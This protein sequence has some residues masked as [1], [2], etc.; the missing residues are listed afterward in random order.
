[1]PNCFK[2]MFL[3]PP[4]DR[5]GLT[6][7]SNLAF[8][9][10]PLLPPPE[11][12]DGPN[13]NAIRLLSRFSLRDMLI[14][15][16]P[17]MVIGGALDRFSNLAFAME[18]DECC[19]CCNSAGLARFLPDAREIL[20]HERPDL[21]A[22]AAVNFLAD[23]ELILRKL[24]DELPLEVMAAVAR[25]DGDFFMPP[26]VGVVTAVGTPAAAM[27]PST[28]AL[29]PMWA[30]SSTRKPLTIRGK[31]GRS[32]ALGCQHL[33]MILRKS[34]EGMVDVVCLHPPMATC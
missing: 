18:R 22:P 20:D 29:A 6:V 14:P 25:H 15:D 23:Q 28:S 24:L 12:I 7:K 17:V 27:A 3:L 1:M 26:P 2:N 16:R 8:V 13:P 4:L 32:S 21:S 11:D 31:L 10:P 30:A 5:L 19:C 9:L 34:F 33:L